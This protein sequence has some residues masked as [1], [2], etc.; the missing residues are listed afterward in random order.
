VRGVLPALLGRGVQRQT[1]AIV[2][3]ANAAEARCIDAL[4][5]HL[6]GHIIE[7]AAHLRGESLPEAK[8]VPRDQR[9]VTSD[10]ADFAEVRGQFA[11]RRALE[12]AAAGHHNVLMIGP[13]GTGKTMLARRLPSILPPM[14]ESEALEVTAIHSVAGL[15][16]ASHGLVEHRPFRAPHHTVSAA[17]LLGG[18]ASVRPGEMT[19]A[20]QGCLFLDELLEF[21]RHVIDGMRQPLE[22]GRVTIARAR[23]S[24]TFPSRPLLVAAV[25]PCPCGYHGTTGPR[26]CRCP[27]ERVERY[28]SRL[29]GPILDRID[30]HVGLAPVSLDDLA[31][32]RVGESSD[33]I[34]ERVVSARER[35]RA[36]HA[37]RETSK[38]YNGELPGT[39]LDRIAPLCSASKRLIERAMTAMGLSARAYVRI[40]RVSLTLADL[41][42][43]NQVRVEDVAEAIAARSLD[44][45][46]E[47]VALAS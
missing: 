41:R 45:E 42:G 27:P 26:S 12:V 44:R 6:A 15:L 25:N 16:T 34:R 24:A 31:G 11:A 36:R 13:P 10:P 1:S 18:G 22:E 32:D 46:P 35:Q 38:P 17:A 7:V 2:P 37:A 14:T 28:R 33:A 21:P 3:S 8:D 47:K 30:L 29:S 20:H 40:R 9:R 23:Y 4:P 39:C 5:V 19:L 43:D